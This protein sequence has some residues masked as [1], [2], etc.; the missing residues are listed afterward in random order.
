MQAPLIR[1][2]ARELAQME[3]KSGRLPAPDP[4]LLFAAHPGLAATAGVVGTLHRDRSI[5]PVHRLGAIPLEPQHH[6][7]TLHPRPL[8]AAADLRGQVPDYLPTKLHEIIV[9]PQ[10]Q[11]QHRSWAMNFELAVAAVG[12]LDMLNDVSHQFFIHV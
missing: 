6:L 3:L 4:Q 5:Q 10:F 12:E 11:P 1:P 2:V 8:V 9:H 7:A